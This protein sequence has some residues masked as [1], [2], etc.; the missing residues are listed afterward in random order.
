MPAQLTRR[1]RKIFSLLCLVNLVLAQ[2]SSKP[3]QLPDVLILGLDTMKVYDTRT[4]FVETSS[5]ALD[6]ARVPEIGMSELGHVKK[7]GMEEKFGRRYHVELKMGWG[8]GSHQ[9]YHLGYLG[10]RTISE[11]STLCYGAGLGIN[12]SKIWPDSARHRYFGVW[13]R[14][15]TW[16]SLASRFE[17]RDYEQRIW[18]WEWPYTRNVRKARLSS[19]FAY[20]LGDHYYLDVP[21]DL[22]GIELDD[23]GPAVEN[24]LKVAPRFEADFLS[25]RSSGGVKFEYSSEH[26]LA[27]P[28]VEYSRKN[29]LPSIKLDGLVLRL[30]C[31]YVD[32]KRKQTFLTPDARLEFFEDRAAFFVGRSYQV[33]DWIREFDEN[34]LVTRTEVWPARVDSSRVEKEK[35]HIGLN[36]RVPK[37]SLDSRLEF[38]RVEQLF[39]WEPDWMNSLAFHG[40]YRTDVS[41]LSLTVAQ[42]FVYGSI[43]SRYLIASEKLPYTYRF[44]VWVGMKHRL[45]PIADL[46]YRYRF[47]TMPYEESGDYSILKLDV[48]I[49]REILKLFTARFEV[50]NIADE[51]YV[52]WPSLEAGR[53]F[54]FSIHSRL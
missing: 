18:A 34:R 38:K 29:L 24:R 16:F 21:V 47:Q 40:R 22:D 48:G 15:Q 12:T 4:T 28:Y 36:G 6:V 39:C 41:I 50:N 45:G 26:L 49:Q 43:G 27:E 10:R 53:H 7:L 13:T 32:D 1:R 37:W 25:F 31:A 3:I 46:D 33:C 44:E 8:T 20:S 30:G 35:V 9:L 5:V 11:G 51:E 54:L 2:G 19:Q 14:W 42:E 23:Q 52:T 17:Y